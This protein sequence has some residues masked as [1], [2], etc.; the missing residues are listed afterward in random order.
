MKPIQIKTLV[1]V[2]GLT[3]LTVIARKRR[4]PKAAPTM[5]ERIKMLAPTLIVHDSPTLLGDVR[6]ALSLRPALADYPTRL[7]EHLG[8]DEQTVR[9]CLEALYLEGSLCP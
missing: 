3:F 8:A 9:V 7:A 6:Q 2:H 4:P 5:P 1:L